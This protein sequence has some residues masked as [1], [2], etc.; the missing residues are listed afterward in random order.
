MN[1]FIRYFAVGGIATAVD[2]SIFAAL[3]YGVDVTWFW[4]AF[5]SFLLATSVNY[6]LSIRHVFESGVRFR[7]RHEIPLVFLVSAVGL[8]VNQA[9]L[10]V[11]I[12]MIGIYPLV[13]KV[14]ATGM[15]FFWNFF[16]RS[17]FI[18]KS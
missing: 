16:A 17:M 14:G 8:V 3:L 1:K 7:K 12:E 9:A 10:Y 2:F 18:F 6:V 4:S 5:V 11:G 13:A 15:V